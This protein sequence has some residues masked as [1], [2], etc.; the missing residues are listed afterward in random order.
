MNDDAFCEPTLGSS[1]SNYWDDLLTFQ[2]TS[3]GIT[4]KY[5]YY[6]TTFQGNTNAS[7]S[8]PNGWTLKHLKCKYFANFGISAYFYF[9]PTNIQ[10]ATNNF[11]PSYCN[12]YTS[13][14]TSPSLKYTSQSHFYNN[15]TPITYVQE[16]DITSTISSITNFGFRN[17]DQMVLSITYTTN[18]WGTIN[19]CAVLGGFS[20]TSNTALSTCVVGSDTNIY[21]TNIAG[22]V[23]TP[24]L[25]STTNMRIKI[26]FIASPGS[27]YATANLDYN[28]KMWLYANYDAYAQGYQAIFYEY[29]TLV[30][31]TGQSS[32]YWATPSWCGLTDNTN[33]MGTFIVQKITDTSMTVVFAPPSTG[34]F[35]TQPYMHDFFINFNGYTFGS[36][37]SVSKIEME[38]SS[39]PV[40]GTG[41][42]NTFDPDNIYVGPHYIQVR[43]SS[44]TWSAYWGGNGL[45][46]DNS[47][48][49]S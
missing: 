6:V 41:F 14:I 34:S 45:A 42:N 22:F 46:S 2:I 40:P 15:G 12:G 47:W 10:V 17:G 25:S 32:C 24:S 36:G 33:V 21:I 20:S 19:S 26:K 23:T 27:T 39:S 49:S 18:Y 35:A 31:G 8:T 9:S 16:F 28:F 37:F 1:S 48:Q 7:T 5:A 38:M 30:S 3:G 4:K 11:S 44:R 43:L 29:N 13:G